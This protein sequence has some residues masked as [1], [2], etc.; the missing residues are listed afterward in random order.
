M[1][2]CEDNCPIFS[3]TKTLIKLLFE[4]T[5]S[6]CCHQKATSIVLTFTL[7]IIIRTLEFVVIFYFIMFHNGVSFLFPKTLVRVAL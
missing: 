4:L 5:R 3:F 1:L 7:F 2:R 6:L